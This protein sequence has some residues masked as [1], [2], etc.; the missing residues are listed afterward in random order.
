MLRTSTV[1]Q[2]KFYPIG[3][4]SFLDTE[5]ERQKYGGIRINLGKIFIT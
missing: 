1:V 5:K 4:R 3:N 2:W